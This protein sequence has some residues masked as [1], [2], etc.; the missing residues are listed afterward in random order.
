MYF[1]T[2][3]EMYSI[4]CYV[5]DMSFFVVHISEVVTC[6]GDVLDHSVATGMSPTKKKERDG[7]LL[8]HIYLVLIT[9]RSVIL[10]E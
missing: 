5:A 10:F 6:M 7:I 4:I 1:H 8:Y 3:G 9:F 2:D